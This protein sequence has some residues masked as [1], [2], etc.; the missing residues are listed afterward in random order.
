[1]RNFNLNEAKNGAPICTRDGKPA[2]IICWDKKGNSP[3]V[4]LIPHEEVAVEKIET[5]TTEGKWSTSYSSSLDLMMASTKHE[6][7]VNI[8][9]RKDGTINMGSYHKTEEEAKDVL[10]HCDYNYITTIHIEWEE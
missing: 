7:W 10:T 9:R 6:G 1:M 2:R 3:I 5:Y 8:Y 4:A